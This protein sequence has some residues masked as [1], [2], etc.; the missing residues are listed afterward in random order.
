MNKDL[1]E[2]YIFM[3]NLCY[4]A[5][6]LH[7]LCCYETTQKD[8]KWYDYG[9]QLTYVPIPIPNPSRPWGVVIVKTVQRFALDIT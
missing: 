3:L 4:K 5:S 7:P 2:N 8:S 6:C 9:L 1:P